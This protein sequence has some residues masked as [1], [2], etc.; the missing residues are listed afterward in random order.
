MRVTCRAFALFAALVAGLGAP[1]SDAWADGLPR[2]DVEGYCAKVADSIGGSE[3]IRLSCFRQEQSAY[4]TLKARWDGVPGK[5]QSYCDQ[6]ASS[7][8]GSYMIL[9]SCLDQEMQAASQSPEFQY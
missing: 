7:I 2:Y 9:N 3:Q 5:T 6:V 8:G 4:N 1:V